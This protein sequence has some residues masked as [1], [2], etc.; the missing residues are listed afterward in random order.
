MKVNKAWQNILTSS[1]IQKKAKCV[2]KEEILKDEM[3]L[4]RAS[5]HGNAE[6]VARLLS[7]GVVNVDFHRRTGNGICNS[8]CR[9]GG[10]SLHLAASFGQK[11]VVQLLIDHGADPNKTDKE[12]YN[13]Y[14]IPLLMSL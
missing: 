1:A 14:Y 5:G 13:Q 11:D 12:G 7:S 10:T 4:L 9:Y 8:D 3:K 6:E 2:F